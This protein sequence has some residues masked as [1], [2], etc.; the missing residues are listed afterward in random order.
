MYIAQGDK[1]WDRV[2]NRRVKMCEWE[3]SWQNK[4]YM[5]SYTIEK[6]FLSFFFFGG[7]SPTFDPCGR[8]SVPP[9]D[10]CINTPTRFLLA[11]LF[12]PF[13][14]KYMRPADRLSCGHFTPAE[15]IFYAEGDLQLLFDSCQDY[16]RVHLS[17]ARKV[18][19]T[20]T[21]KT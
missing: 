6:R 5:L 19:W 13:A 9:F 14:P 18:T 1:E 10:W 16:I 11:A 2:A 7:S 17:K 20:S 8:S 4:F 21:C 15:L 3:K 12:I